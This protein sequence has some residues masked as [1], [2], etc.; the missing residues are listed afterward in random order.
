M[1]SVGVGML[2]KRCQRV[3]STREG[4]VWVEFRDRGG[5]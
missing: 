4:L 1:A 3:S 5:N 2:V